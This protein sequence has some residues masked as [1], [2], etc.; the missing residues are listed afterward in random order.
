MATFLNSILKPGWL[1]Q[2]SG[3]QK[4]LD[5]L[6]IASSFKW[7]S[8]LILK[9]QQ[10]L[11]NLLAF[12]LVLGLILNIPILVLF[13]KLTFLL[14]IIVYAP[15]L[16]LKIK[17]DRR[18]QLLQKEIPYVIDMLSMCI[19]SGMNIEQS[20]IYIGQKLENNI[21]KEFQKLS[22]LTQLG[23]SFEQALIRLQKYLPL[24]EFKNLTGSIIN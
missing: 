12:I 2:F 17:S 10:A 6:V 3:I 13:L 15:L 18:K 14:L 21:A 4:K 20:F 11:I 9:F 7:N 19:H 1:L 5:H 22:K 16:F 23:V 24:E 8:N